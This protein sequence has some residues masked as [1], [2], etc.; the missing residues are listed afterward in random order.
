MPDIGFSVNGLTRKVEL[1]AE[2]A[3]NNWIITIDRD[4]SVEF[5]HNMR[6]VEGFPS[7]RLTKKLTNA[8]EILHPEI[9]AYLNNP[10]N[11]LWWKIKNRVRE[12]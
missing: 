6:P 9:V 5:L 1:Y 12:L 10:N 11:E 8:A 3:K 2:S 7:S 4:G